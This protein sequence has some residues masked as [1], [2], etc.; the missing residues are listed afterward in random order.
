MTAEPRTLSPDDYALHFLATEGYL[1]LSLSEHPALLSAYQ[2]LFTQ[3]AAFF[4]LPPE[5]PLKTSFQAASGATAS[6]EG[7]SQIPS[8]KSIATIKIASN[9]PNTLLA[10]AEEAWRASGTFLQSIARAI[11][12]T[13]HLDSEAFAPF[14]DPCVTLPK[15]ERTPTLLRLFRYDR[16]PGPNP[17]VN[18]ER[19]R[20]LGLLSLVIGQSPGLHVLS[21]ASGAWIPIEESAFLPPGTKERSGGLTATLLG[22]QTLA[23][24]T[25]GKYRAGEHGVV[26]NPPVTKPPSPSSSYSKAPDTGT[27]RFGEDEEIFR[28]SVVFTLRPAVAP[29]YTRNFESDIVGKYPQELVSDGTSSAELFGRIRSVH[30]NVNAAPA[31]REEQKARA[32]AKDLKIGEDE[33]VALE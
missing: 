30:Y 20:D 19:H 31:I 7:F 1:P 29:V 4:A 18:A 14:V 5:S 25:R 26:C 12:N 17:V 8:E 3:S 2:S 15:T 13:L 23:Y 27:N 22:G 10:P 9:C 6:E 24:L 32:R 28:Y 21:S 11:A 33:S 16:P